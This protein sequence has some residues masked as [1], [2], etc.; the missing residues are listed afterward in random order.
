[1][2]NVIRFFMGPEDERA[3]FRELAPLGLELYPELVPA[4][5]QPP[6]VEESLAATL[7]EPSYYLGAPQIGPITVDKVKRGPNKGK[8][9]IFEVVSPVI[10]YQRSL[11]DE[12]GILRS[13]MIWAELEVSGD[14]QRRVQKAAAFEKLYR[15]VSDIVAR[16]ARKSQPVG[17]LVL[18]DAVKLHQ[19]G[20]ELREEGRKGAVIRPFR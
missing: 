3:F 9:M 15:Q 8:W 12:D 18:P 2:A 17:Y 5:W 10:H 14:V 6:Q 1:M 7:D 11:V 20:T 16:R 13:G 4:N 19:A